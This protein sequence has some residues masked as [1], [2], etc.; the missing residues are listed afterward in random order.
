MTDVNAWMDQYLRAWT[1]NEPD[2]IRAL[3]TEDA[4]YNT[5]PNSDS[6]W[7]G[8]DEIVREWSG[9]SADQPEDWTFEWTLLGRD[10]DTAFIQGLTTYLNGEPTYDNLWV[11]RFAEDGRARDFTE[12]FMARKPN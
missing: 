9:D 5:R 8:H 12:W 10:G 1:S 7:R 11:I 6:P 3:F 2:E 4:V